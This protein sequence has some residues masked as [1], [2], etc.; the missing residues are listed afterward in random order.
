M[1]AQQK[2]ANAGVKVFGYEG[3]VK[4]ALNDFMSNTLGGLEACREGHEHGGGCH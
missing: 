3:I 2:F 1:G 4:D